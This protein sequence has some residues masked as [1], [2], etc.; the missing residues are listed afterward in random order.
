MATCSVATDTVFAANGSVFPNTSGSVRRSLA[1]SFTSTSEQALSK[2]ELCVC[3]NSSRVNQWRSLGIDQSE[4]SLA[5][6]LPTGQS[7][8]WKLTGDNEYTGV[9][10]E[11]LFTL[12]QTPTDVEFVLHNTC[13]CRMDS[14]IM[15]CHVNDG[16]HLANY[17]LHATKTSQT[18]FSSSNTLARSVN[19]GEAATFK[20]NKGAENRDPHG[21]HAVH[22]SPGGAT[23]SCETHGPQ[24][25]C[26]CLGCAEVSLK[27]YFN[28]DTSLKD[29]WA[30]FIAADARFATLAPYM[31]GA[32]L[33]RQR[34]L[35][36]LFQFIC[37]SNNHIQRISQMVDHLAGLGPYLGNVSGVAFHSFPT[38]DVLADV[39]EADLRKAGFGYRAKY[40]VGAVK[41]LQLKKGGGEE[42]LNSLRGKTLDNTLDELCS[43]PGIGPKVASCVSLFLLDQHHAIPVDTHVW[44]VAKRILKACWLEAKVVDTCS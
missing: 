36:C 10:D 43:L 18:K 24:Y 41:E 30:P 42:W 40:I 23:Y 8:R 26:V 25:C 4:L 16:P 5:L 14:P 12:R 20:C 32:R 11:Y 3:N 37:S 31:R 22:D 21:C 7:F 1:S 28:L 15:L 39:T 33:L 44:R 2:P 38:L 34:P 29:V 19:A 6:T 9:V 35:E 17:M 13:T 27:R